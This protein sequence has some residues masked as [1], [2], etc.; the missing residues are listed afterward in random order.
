M[1]HNFKKNTLLKHISLKKVYSK[2]YYKN[3]LRIGFPLGLQ[4]MLF[5]VCSMVVVAFV[6]EF[7]DAAVAKTEGRYTGRKYFLVYGDW[8]PDIY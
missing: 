1:R 8:I 7:G 3:I 5:S 2:F 4:S 6:A